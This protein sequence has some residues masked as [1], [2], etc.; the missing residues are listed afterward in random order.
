MGVWAGFNYLDQIRRKHGEPLASDLEQFAAA[1]S[2]ALRDVIKT[3]ASSV[4]DEVSNTIVQRAEHRL[5]LQKNT[6]VAT[7]ANTTETT[8]WEDTVPANT[9]DKDGSVLV[10]RAAGDFAN[11]ANGKQLRFYW[12]GT[13]IV[14]TGSQGWQDR[15]WQL[16]ALISRR[17]GSSQ[18]I[19]AQFIPAITG[20]SASIGEFATAT[21]NLGTGI[22]FKITGQNGT[23]AASDITFELGF[24]EK[25]K[26]P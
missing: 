10:I 3:K 16:H 26:A 17:G 20:V 25:L 19:H 13:Q 7:G 15:G 1:V 8:F 14:A 4:T 18:A 6:Q 5:V 21:A 11:N 23:A 12:N 22:I 9:L 2:Q 24:V